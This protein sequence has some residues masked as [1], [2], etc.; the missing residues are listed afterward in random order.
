MIDTV[1]TGGGLLMTAVLT[2]AGTLLLW[3]HNFVSSDSHSQLAAEQSYFRAPNCAAVAA[4]E[5]KAMRQYGGDVDGPVELAAR[6]RHRF[7]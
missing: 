7:H 4:P 1:L 3:A 6:Q 5:L 2:V